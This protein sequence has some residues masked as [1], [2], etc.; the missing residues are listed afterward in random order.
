MNRSDLGV[1]LAFLLLGALLSI[2]T[3]ALP[4][5]LGG[6]PGPGFFPRMIGVAMLA[7]ASLL[8][9]QAWR[10]PA[11]PGGRAQAKQALVTI[12]LLAAYLALWDPVPFALRTLLFAALY[13]R[14]LGQSWRAA[15]QVALGLTIFVVAAFQYGLRVGLP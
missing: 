7:L 6:L 2:W 3:A 5:S 1:A 10:R 15:V 8:F 12:L 9:A 14:C 13:L 4:P 11:P